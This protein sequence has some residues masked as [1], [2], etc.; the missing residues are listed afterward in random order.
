MLHY[1]LMAVGTNMD[2]FALRNPHFCVFLHELNSHD[3]AKLNFYT[4]STSSI[5]IY[6]L[7]KDFLF[8]ICNI[9]GAEIISYLAVTWA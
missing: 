5:D 3:K 1:W 9:Q 4:H 2:Q 6:Q 8:C 7:L